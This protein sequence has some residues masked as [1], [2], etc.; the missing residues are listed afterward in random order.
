MDPILVVTALGSML[1]VGYL[2]HERGRSQ[3]RWVWTAALIG[4]LAI[5]LLYLADAA[6]AARKALGA[7]N[8]N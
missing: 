4:P 5:P 8:A 7:V 2:A 3:T 1:V 6:A